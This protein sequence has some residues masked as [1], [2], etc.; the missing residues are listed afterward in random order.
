MSGAGRHR[1]EPVGWGGPSPG[2]LRHPPLLPWGRP[3]PRAWAA[4]RGLQGARPGGMGR[5]EAWRCS[6][7]GVQRFS[8]NRLLVP[9]QEA[10]LP[11]EVA[12]GAEQHRCCSRGP[13]G[14]ESRNVHRV[15]KQP[16]SPAVPHHQPWGTQ[17]CRRQWA[18]LRTQAQLTLL[19]AGLPWGAA[20]PPPA[21]LWASRQPA[22]CWR[23][24]WP[25]SSVAG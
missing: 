20:G 14:P 8:R 3:H 25:A 2:C 22:A 17:T 19:W 9:C 21:Y 12:A 5:R 10:A 23:S 6:W 1:A 15:P 13:E 4:L 16:S 24:A 7:G 18:P 11:G